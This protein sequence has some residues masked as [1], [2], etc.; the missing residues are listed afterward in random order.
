ME[1][2]L[3]W[4]QALWQAMMRDGGI[5]GHA[6]LLKG[7]EGIGK[8]TFT[9]L[10]AKALLC[11]NR[12]TEIPDSAACGKCA[13]CNWFEQQTHPNFTVIVPEKL[14]VEQSGD[15]ST[16]E[17]SQQSVDNKTK[18]KPSQQIGINQIRGLD[19]FVYLTGHQSG[20]KIVLIYPAEAMNSAASNALLKKLEEPPE[21]VLFLLVTHQPQRLLPTIRSRCHQ[22]AMPVPDMDT[23]LAWLKQQVE[24][25]DLPER[26]QRGRTFDMSGEPDRLQTLL[27][28]SGFAPFKALTL[29]EY[30]ERHRQFVSSLNAVESFDPLAM[31]DMLKDQDLSMTVD[32]M[33]KWCHDVSCY[34]ATGSIRYH[35]CDQAGI[36]AIA[37][38][39]NPQMM[40]VYQ[41]F[42]CR[43]RSLAQHTVQPR[44][45]LEDMLVRYYALVTPQANA[46]MSGA[47]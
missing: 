23:A 20:Y 38:R 17:E 19:D 12:T 25:K 40:L 8:L 42:L 37:K 35:P 33:Q 41:R 36:R 29:E 47:V 43:H 44:L 24:E 13:G 31:A 30:Y 10:L 22:I 3:D 21:Q 16:E 39:I 28:L 27:S 9:R 34:A 15:T 18:K 11:K 1:T 7:R 14:M 4:Q 46:L 26:Q 5:R 45:F 2:I 6:L 32:W